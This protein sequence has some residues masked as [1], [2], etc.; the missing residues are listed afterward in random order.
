[1]A[2]EGNGGVSGYSKPDPNAG[3]ASRGL[4]PSCTE[5]ISISPTTNGNG[6]GF[7]EPAAGLHVT[8]CI[9]LLQPFCSPH[10]KV[11]NY[12]I[13]VPFFPPACY[14]LPKALKLGKE[15]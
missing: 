1:M 3:R 14:S 4:R 6:P 11:C 7:G 2:R 5:A 8:Q 15:M 9:S 12:D 13:S 10:I